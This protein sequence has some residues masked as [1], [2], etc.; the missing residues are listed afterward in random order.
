[1]FGLFRRQDPRFRED[2]NFLLCQVRTDAHGEVIK[3]RL[4]KTSEMS[5]SGG[6]YFVRKT[7]IGPRSL[8]NATLEVTMNRSH[9]VVSAAVD[10]GELLRTDEWVE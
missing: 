7:L 2:G 9:R 3:V 8:D 1:M 10:G 4:S 6:G 5:V